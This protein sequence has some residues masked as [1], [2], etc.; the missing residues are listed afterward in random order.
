MRIFK[1]EEILT[2]LNYCIENKRPFSVIRFGDGGIKYIDALLCREEKQLDPIV[3]KEGLPVDNLVG[4][5][6]KWGYYAR[7]ADFIDCPEVYFMD[8]FWARL[9]GSSK[10]ISKETEEKLLNWKSLYYSAEFDNENY[11]NPEL[12]YL[13]IMRMGEKKNL[14][15]LMKRRKVCI[16]TPF[17]KIREVLYPFN[18]DIVKIVGQYEDQYYNSFEEVSKRIKQDGKK[19]DF[20][21]VAAGEL[22]RLYSGMIKENGGRSFDLGFVIEFWL[23]EELHPRL[24]LF[25]ERSIDNSFELSLTER[26]RKYE[27]FI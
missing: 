8:T 27:E 4:I 19:Y 14:L 16:I 5:L 17:P 25:L 21:L 15:D 6:N 18:V 3:I 1:V 10:K 7:R 9:K 13:S 24:R 26:G 11:C 22:G 12:N 23:G 20:W 2:K